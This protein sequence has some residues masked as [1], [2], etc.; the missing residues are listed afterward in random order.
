MRGIQV[1]RVSW[2]TTYSGDPKTR[3]FLS[4]DHFICTE[5]KLFLKQ[6]RLV[7]FGCYF[8]FLPFKI[9]ILN[10]YGFRMVGFWIPTV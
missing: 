3:H 8:V 2:H 9:W 1:K 4:L 7:V 10:V 6:S 5:E